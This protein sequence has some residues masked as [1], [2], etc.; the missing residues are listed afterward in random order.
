[1]LT[2][3][4]LNYFVLGFITFSTIFIYGFQRLLKI[5]L[6]I[7]T[8]GERVRWMASNKKLVIVILAITISASLYLFFT[9]WEDALWIFIISAFFSFF[10]VWEV[11]GLKGKNLRDIPGIKIYIIALIWV[12]VCSLLP[13]LVDSH[14]ITTQ[15]LWLFIS[16]FLF[17]VSIIIPFDIR[18]I[19]LDE[20]TKKTIPQV[21]GELRA[22]YLSI[23]LL[24]SSQIILF[25]EYKNMGSLIFAFIS[26]IILYK[27][28]S[29]RHDMYFSA[30][31]DGLLIL[32]TLLLWIFLSLNNPT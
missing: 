32:Q 19:H 6:K 13:V 20:D 4:K 10:Y 11:P 16:H 15:I 27:A 5:E 1:M 23:A 3:N 31:T 21:I 14:P 30:L 7:N 22:R 12:L 26:I 18:D 8:Q 25:L 28:N 24:V 17:M 2:Q 9:F 29:K